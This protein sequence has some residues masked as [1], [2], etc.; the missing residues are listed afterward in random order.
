MVRTILTTSLHL[1]HHILQQPSLLPPTTTGL[2]ELGAGAGFLSILLAQLSWSVIA[3]D[4]EAE[5]GET[6]AAPLAR[7]GHNVSLSASNQG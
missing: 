3:T 1:A 5:E 2:V 4:L 6:R 7:L